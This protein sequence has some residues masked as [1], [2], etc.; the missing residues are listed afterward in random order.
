M[1]S[2]PILLTGKLPKAAAEHRERIAVYLT[3]GDRV[4]AEVSPS[5]EGEVKIALDRE[6]A[7]GESGLELVVGPSGLGANISAAPELVRVPVDT[8]AIAKGGAEVRVAID[9][10]VLN[11]ETFEIWWRWCSLYCVSG[12]VIGQNGCPVP[13]AEVTVYSVD[14]LLTKTPRRTV[15]ADGDGRFSACFN[16]CECL[17]CCWP[18]WP[19]WW[20]CWPW[21]WEWDILHVIER[22]EEQIPRVPVGPGP[23]ENFGLALSRPETSVLARGEAFA[24]AR[25]SVE[26]FEA[27]EDRTAL[28]RRK[29]SSPAI[30]ELFPWWWWCCDDPN[31]C[32]SATQDGHTVVLEN[33][34]TDTR[35]CFEEGQ[36]VTLV[37]NK[38]AITACPP[39]HG[40][41][42]GFLWIRVGDTL[43]S[44]IHE[45][46]A[47]GSFYPSRDLAF[48]AGLDIYGAFPSS[49]FYY[50]L[51]AEPWAGDPAR[52]GS[53]S[54]SSASIKPSLSNT[55]VIWHRTTTNAVTFDAVQMGPFDLGGLTGLYA[56]QEHRDG[57]PAPWPPLPAH[58]PG[59]V[60][61]WGFNG[62]V[63]DAEASSL[64]G[65]ATSG[66]V[67]LSVTGFDG[68]FNPV[69][70]ASN[71]D[72]HLTLLVDDSAALTTAR[73][74]S[75]RVFNPGAVEVFPT[76]TGSC[77]SYE[78]ELGGY[79]VVNVTVADANEH[80]EDYGV[81][82]DFGHGSIGTTVPGTRNYGDPPASFPFG[83][84]NP[85][86]TAHKAFGG[87]T[88]DFTF[89]PLESCCYDFRLGVAKRVTNGTG[90]PGGYTA[91]FW[92]AT[93]KI[94]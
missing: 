5:P 86:D 65:G 40:L 69:A 13:F 79:V 57:A 3:S 29:L 1:A 73:I 14:F 92:T 68:L 22:I 48:W 18:C 37:A 84:A 25:K 2:D 91:D 77:P 85:P 56:T 76:G 83:Y 30:R 24:T 47:D 41:K 55:V 16:W 11:K 75:L 35:W 71:P 4:L 21:W 15:L 64:I 8:G 90:S 32:F 59:D 70:L 50:Q 63:V 6:R 52:G 43:V 60:V 89:T 66:A 93:I 80:I 81:T 46:Y 74:N 38:Q 61:V 39:P 28:V 54:G 19:R 82:P 58:N 94:V 53:A 9:K 34:A 51:D 49:V 62:R 17:F 42:D 12:Q 36:S 87:G 33:P 44:E 67:T 7:L 45:G 78:I 27:D 88:E 10:A 20:W 31:I 72:D 23:V 26:R